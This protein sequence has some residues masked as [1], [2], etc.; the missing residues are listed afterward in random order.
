LLAA[1]PSYMLYLLTCYT[2]SNQHIHFP[3]CAN[4]LVNLPKKEEKKE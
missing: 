4:I 3:F 2:I 1:I